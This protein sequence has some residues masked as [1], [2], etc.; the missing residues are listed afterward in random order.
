MAEQVKEENNDY[1]DSN[2]RRYLI[3]G[4]ILLV[5]AIAIGVLLVQ[6][7]NLEKERQQQEM[8]LNTAYIQ[9]DSI[10]DE[11]DER[12]R[13]ISELGG[14]IDTLLSIRERLESEKKE[15]LDREKS[16]DLTIRNLRDKVE[17]YQ[18]L[19]VI[20][21]EEI[22]QLSVINEQLL[23]ENSDLKTE[24]QELNQVI[25]E[26]EK[27]KEQLQQQID[28]VAQLKVEGMSVFAVNVN[29]KEREAEFRNRHIDQLKIQFTV[30]ENKVAPIEG[31]ALLVKITA[32]DGNVLFDVTRGSGTFMFEGREMF[33]TAKKE[34]LFDRNR[35]QVIL[36]YD[37][38][39]EFELGIHNVQVY[40]D[41]YLMGEG[42]FVIKG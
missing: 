11:L 13:T 12:I 40:T 14:E 3:I 19:L 9:L 4:S 23:T 8:A 26:T 5:F 35:Q 18:E 34:I 30:A 22:K 31:K 2:K 25:R 28:L 10:S 36:F 33:Y 38:G 29:G 41:E 27:D 1:N 16:K 37:K 17:G 15:L 7:N 39:S 24:T 6:K 42:S 20:K 21:D 32:P